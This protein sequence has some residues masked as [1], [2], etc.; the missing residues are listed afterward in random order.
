MKKEDNKRKKKKSGKTSVKCK[1]TVQKIRE[2]R[3]DNYVS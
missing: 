1:R 3:K 2:K